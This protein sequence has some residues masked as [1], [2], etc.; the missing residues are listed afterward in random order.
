[1]PGTTGSVFGLTSPVS[2]F[3]VALLVSVGTDGPCV[4]VPRGVIG[5]VLGLTGPVSVYCVVLSGRWW[6]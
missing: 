6:D 5:L 1:M 2:V 4:S 3:H